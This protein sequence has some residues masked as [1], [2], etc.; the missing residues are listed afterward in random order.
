MSHI[1]GIR[2]I[3]VFTCLLSS[4]GCNGFSSAQTWHWRPSKPMKGFRSNETPSD[5]INCNIFLSLAAYQRS[6]Q[7]TYFLW[8][9]GRWRLKEGRCDGS[10]SCLILSIV[11][12]NLKLDSQKLRRCLRGFFFVSSGNTYYQQLIDQP[13][14]ECPNITSKQIIQKLEMH[15]AATKICN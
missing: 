6:V 10:D 2:N 4:E 8:C 12:K 5:G 13:P 14:K 9:V 1:M 11:L 3:L 7:T 15:V